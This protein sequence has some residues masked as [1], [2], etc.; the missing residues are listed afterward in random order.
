MTQGHIY[1]SRARPPHPPVG[2]EAPQ[3]RG[4]REEE[5]GIKGTNFMATSCIT[6]SPFTRHERRRISPVAMA[7]RA[8]DLAQ[9]L[10]DAHREYDRL[11]PR[12]L[13][14]SLREVL[15][16]SAHPD[17]A[18]VQAAEARFTDYVA[19]LRLG[20]ARQLLTLMYIGR[21]DYTPRTILAAN[22]ALSHFPTAA[23]IAE[24]MAGKIP[25]VEYL[26]RG[27]QAVYGTEGGEV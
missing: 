10:R 9:Q 8:T 20:H 3:G 26:E 7:I 6:S 22:R 1:L 16:A 5:I 17:Y 25:L 13:I 23:V 15:A 14:Q 11:H 2:A 12:A 4:V 19:G 27:I 24:Q 21:G 18:A